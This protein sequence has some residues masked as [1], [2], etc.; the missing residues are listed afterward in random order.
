MVSEI[1]HFDL[2]ADHLQSIDEKSLAYKKSCRRTS[3]IKGEGTGNQQD[4]HSELSYLAKARPTGN[5]VEVTTEH[6]QLGNNGRPAIDDSLGCNWILGRPRVR[7]FG[8]QDWIE[9]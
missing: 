8:L 4:F 5:A 6:R 7:I 2:L 9:T 3:R 1:Q